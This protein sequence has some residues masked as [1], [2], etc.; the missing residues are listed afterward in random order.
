[1]Q[2]RAMKSKVSTAHKS[3]IAHLLH[4]CGVNGNTRHRR[5]D[6]V[7]NSG[8]ILARFASLIYGVACKVLD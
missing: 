3:G 6:N 4:C 2:Q 5:E 7:G 1:M 8:D